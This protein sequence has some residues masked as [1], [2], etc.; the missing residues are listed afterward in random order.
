[1]GALPVEV[2]LFEGAHGLRLLAERLGAE[3]V[4]VEPEAAARLVELCGGLPIPL[5]V[6]ASTLLR[7][8]RSSIADLVD[9]LPDEGQ[10]L[11]RLTEEGTATV[12]EVIDRAYRSLPDDAAVAYRRLGAHPGPDFDLAVASVLCDL[13]ERAAR[14]VIDVLCDARLLDDVTPRRYRFH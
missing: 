7:H 11:Q 5:H 9:H 14:R 8:P 10:G 2:G 13:P 12:S 3:R 4:D 1:D 6:A